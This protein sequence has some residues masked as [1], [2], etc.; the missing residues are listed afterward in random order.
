MLEV[1]PPRSIAEFVERVKAAVLENRTAGHRAQVPWKQV[2]A[3]PLR[4][5]EIQKLWIQSRKKP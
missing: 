5:T 2:R 4:A 3:G 1:Q